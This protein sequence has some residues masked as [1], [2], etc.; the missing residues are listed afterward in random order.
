MEEMAG[1]KAPRFI[2]P[3]K[4]KIVCEGEVVIMEATVESFPTCSFQW[5]LHDT[6]IKVLLIIDKCKLV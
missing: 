2:Q 5:F 6:P 3:L 1:V 4:P